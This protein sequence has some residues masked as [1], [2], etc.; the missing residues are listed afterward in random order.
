ME[1]KVGHSQSRLA[2]EPHRVSSMFLL[3]LSETKILLLEADPVHCSHPVCLFRRCC[4]RLESASIDLGHFRDSTANRNCSMT[5]S[6]LTAS[7]PHGTS[8]MRK[9][10][11]DIADAAR[12]PSSPLLL[13][14]LC[15]TISFLHCFRR[16][17][18]WLQ[19]STCF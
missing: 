13:L 11:H 17:L 2:H 7:R 10:L 6:N 18:S 4:C 12:L 9:T 8:P 16:S 15:S 5:L 3:S 19:F 14:P 1:R